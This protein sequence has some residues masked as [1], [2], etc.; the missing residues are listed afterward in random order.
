MPE[1]I[2]LE[3][4][5]VDDPGAA[6]IAADRG[7][8]HLEGGG[9]EQQAPSEIHGRVHRHGSR[10]P[11]SSATKKQVVLSVATCR[12][13]ARSRTG[14]PPPAGRRSPDRPVLVHVQ[15]DV[16]IHHPLRS[17]PARGTDERQA[18]GA[19][20]ERVLDAPPHHAVHRLFTS[21]GRDGLMTMPPSGIGARSRFPELAEVDDLPQT[22]RL[23]GEAVLV[24]DHAGIE[25]PVQQRRLDLREQHFG[26]VASDPERR[27]HT[28]N[29]RWC[30]SPEWRCVRSPLATSRDRSDVWISAADRSSARARSRRPAARSVSAQYA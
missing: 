19:M 12:R 9:I 18:V 23:V 2:D 29:W 22:P 20:C 28:E 7:R 27:G 21:S 4:I 14:L 5:V 1:L 15:V 3:R 25:A 10:S 13:A 26:L 30:I 6:Q 16:L 11:P 17:S 24:D 8:R